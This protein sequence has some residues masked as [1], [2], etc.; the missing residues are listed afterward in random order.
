QWSRYARRRR[1]GDAGWPLGRPAGAPGTGP[2]RRRRRGRSVGSGPP[3]PPEPPGWLGSTAGPR[4]FCGASSAVR[5]RSSTTRTWTACAPNPTPTMA[6]DRDP[7]R[8]RAGMPD[9]DHDPAGRPVLVVVRGYH[10]NEDLATLRG[11]TREVRPGLV[12]VGG[13]A[14]ALLEEGYRPDLIVGDMDSVT[15]GALQSGAEIVLHAYPSGRAPGRVRH[16]ALGLPHR[17]VQ[18]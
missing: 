17:T 12:G 5:S 7:P 16:T 8:R 13:G 9:L 15:E 1:R 10:Y 11:Y 14:D 18:A 2:G 3:G 4:T 6:R